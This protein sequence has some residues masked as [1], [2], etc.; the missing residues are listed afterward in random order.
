MRSYT[1]MEGLHT[2]FTSHGPL[3]VTAVDDMSVCVWCNNQ[4]VQY[5]IYM[6]TMTKM[7]PQEGSNVS[8]TYTMIY[9][10][11]TSCDKHNIVCR[12]RTAMTFISRN[13]DT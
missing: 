10:A 8:M 9:I 5:T 7:S 1:M 3:V 6:Y 2:S 13:S 11:C 12:P 4:V